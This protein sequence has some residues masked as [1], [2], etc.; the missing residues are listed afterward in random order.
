MKY[1]L[2]YIIYM[3]NKFPISQQGYKKLIL[4]L[5]KL[6]TVKRL[7]I[8][9]AISEARSYGDLSENAEYHAARENQSFV[10]AKISKLGLKILAIYP[11]FSRLYT[12]FS[13]TSL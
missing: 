1:S 3:L 7:E 10:E 11:S 4:E 5:K 6:K 9:N 13:L 12:I 2:F 8:I